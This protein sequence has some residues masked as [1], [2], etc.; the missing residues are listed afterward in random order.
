MNSESLTS[1]SSAIFC[2]R[3]TA[4]SIWL[5]LL[6]MENYLSCALSYALFELPLGRYVRVAVALRRLIRPQG[7]AVMD[8]LMDHFGLLD[9]VGDKGAFLDHLFGPPL[10]IEVLTVFVRERLQLGNRV[11]AARVHVERRDIAKVLIVAE[12]NDVV[13]LLVVTDNCH[14]LRPA[15]RLGAVVAETWRWVQDMTVIRDDQKAH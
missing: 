8:C 14:V 6:T 5:A 12:V 2:L 13:G 1:A 7:A 11:R 10:P 4:S 15:P 3:L 9:D